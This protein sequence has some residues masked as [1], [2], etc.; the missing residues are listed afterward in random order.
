[1][2][3]LTAESRWW[4]IG[5]QLKLDHARIHHDR[6]TPLQNS[7]KVYLLIIITGSGDI[8]EFNGSV[9]RVLYKSKSPPAK[10]PGNVS[11]YIACGARNWS[12][13]PPSDSQRSESTPE[14]RFS[15]TKRCFS[16]QLSLVRQ[17]INKFEGVDVLCHPHKSKQSSSNPL[18]TPG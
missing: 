16:R 18:F 2:I 12:F 6:G 5:S 7:C 3:I 15:Q 10:N 13:S 8:R 1:M 11:C 17:S 9:P 4:E 14:A